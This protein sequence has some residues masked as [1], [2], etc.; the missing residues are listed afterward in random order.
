ML[1]RSGKSKTK[2]SNLIGEPLSSLEKSRG[3]TNKYREMAL[4]LHVLST[5]LFLTGHW[6]P[7]NMPS[8]LR[9]ERGTCLLKKLRLSSPARLKH[10]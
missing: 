1:D 7:W 4:V 3:G 9:T 10:V 8:T 6:M 5:V 2:A